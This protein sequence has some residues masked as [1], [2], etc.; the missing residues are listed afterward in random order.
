MTLSQVP[1][2]AFGGGVI[3]LPQEDIILS[4]LA[5]DPS[6]T[7]NSNDLGKAFNDGVML[8]GNGKLTVRPFGLVGHQS[9]GVSWSDKERF[10]LIPRTSPACC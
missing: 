9:L 4:A 10:S 8:V 6:G 2:S 1:I 3:V 7:P 5:L